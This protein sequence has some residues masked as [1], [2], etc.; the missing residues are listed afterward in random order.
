MRHANYGKHRGWWLL[1][2][3]LVLTFHASAQRTTYRITFTDKGSESFTPG[4]PLYG[5]TVA[6]FHPDAL[7]RRERM[8]KT[9]LLDSLDKPLA[10]EYLQGLDELGIRPTARMR[11]RN[12]V[13]AELDPLTATMVKFLPFVARVSPTSSADYR[14]VVDHV[15]CSPARPGASMAPHNL[16]NTLRLLDAGVTGKGATVCLIDNGFR[17]QGMST[18]Q[19]ADVRASY[20]FIY[21]DPDVGNAPSEPEDQD[22]HGSLVFSIAAGWQHDSLIGIAPFATYLLAKTEDMRYERRVEEDLYTAA[23]EWAERNGADVMSSS[24]G[25]FGYDNGEDTLSYDD[26]DGKRSFMAQAIN[27]AVGLGVTCVTAA[28]NSGPA[29]RTIGLPADADSVIAVGGVSW[30][31][32]DPYF[33]TS[34]GPTADGRQKPEVAALALGVR[35]QS[36]DGTFIRASGTSMAAPQIAGLMAMATQVYPDLPPWVLRRAMYEASSAPDSIGTFLGN[37]IPDALAMMRTIGERHGPGIGPPAVVQSTDVQKVIFAVFSTAFPRVDLLLDGE[38]SPL[39]ADAMD[40]LLYN[41]DVADSYFQTDTV[42]GRIRAELNGTVR[43]FPSDSTWFPIQRRGSVVPCAMRL[44]SFVVSVATSE[45]SSLLASPRI[46]PTPTPR[47][48]QRVE[49]LGCRQADTISL[50]ETSTGAF[51]SPLSWHTAMDGRL[52]VDLP[53]VASGTYRVVVDAA[54]VRTVVP[55][56]VY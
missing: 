23:V 17:T 9:P 4:S 40:D 51:V 1:A 13:I 24:L 38:P 18:L 21:D 10:Q 28:G 37:G 56:I 7:R 53:A 32:R 31:D 6:E 50:F 46:A 55:L 36:L 16:L 8:G 14:P 3:G 22:G 30:P 34:Q 12:C 29:P 5:S 48:Q 27:R 2:I 20:D 19:H 47:G 26:L 33:F 41:V 52:L 42:R 44:P 39:R 49:L 35:A 54:S 11:W 25:Y 15:D 45:A 43:Y